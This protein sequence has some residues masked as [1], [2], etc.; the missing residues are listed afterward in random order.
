MHSVEF[1]ELAKTKRQ[2]L[3]KRVSIKTYNQAK[4]VIK[5]TVG[6]TLL[7]IGLLMVVL[8]GPATL[9]IP[10]ALG[11]LATEFFWAKWLLAKFNKTILSLLESNRR[12]RRRRKRK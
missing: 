4:R 3:L 6:I 11:I 2:S 1:L 5:I 9:V 7:L 12:Y 10:L 8:P